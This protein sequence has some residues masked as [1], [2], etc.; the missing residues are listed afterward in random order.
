MEWLLNCIKDDCDIAFW[1]LTPY[2]IAPI[3]P[4]TNKSSLHYEQL[5]V[6]MKFMYVHSKSNAIFVTDTGS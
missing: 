6:N 4:G 1:I 5:D 3:I 2:H